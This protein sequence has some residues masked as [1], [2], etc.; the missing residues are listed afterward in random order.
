MVAAGNAK[1][2]FAPDM[3][4]AALG[5]PVQVSLLID[6][7]ADLFTAAPIRIK[8]DPKLL[9]LNDITPGDLFTKDG[10][11]VTSVKDIRNELGEAVV[12]VSRAQGATG[13]A[14][15]G[16]GLILNFKAIGRGEGS[17]TLPELELRNAKLQPL[18]IA[19]AQLTVKVH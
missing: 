4:D 11:H 5:G 8:Y 16:A 2:R 18:A 1:L 15:S 3:V 7:A 6:N 12:T 17:V 13:V 10:V 14:G 9:K 19:P